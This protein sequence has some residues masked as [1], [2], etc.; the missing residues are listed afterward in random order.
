M[1]MKKL[2]TLILTALLVC[3]LLIANGLFAQTPGTLTCTFTTTSSGGYTPK[4]CFAVWIETSS[5][6][7]IKTKIKQSSSSNMDHLATLTSH[8]NYNN[9]TDAVAG[10]TRT[11]NGL[12]TVTWNGTDL[13]PAVVADGGYKV[14]V[15][16]AW[17]S[18]LTTGKTVQ[19]FSFTKG[20]ATDHQTPASTTNITGITLDWVPTYVGIDENQQKEA[21]SVTPNPVNSQ[22]TVTY[23]LNQP[24]DVTISLSDVNGK[25]VKVL[26]D[27]NQDAGNYSMPL[28]VNAK[29]GIYF[30]KFYTGRTEHTER[31]VITQ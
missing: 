6:T 8:T 12:V 13:T 14:W 10:T 24:S 18:S 15:E 30:L 31:I 3:P 21:F 7:F 9:Y 23:S 11:T 5:G 1:K 22:S 26:I 16:F 29:P 27:E 17:G 2:H 19:S 25:L 4:N 28:S 20:T